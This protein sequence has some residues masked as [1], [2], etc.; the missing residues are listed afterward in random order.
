MSRI[1]EGPN[2]EVA[3]AAAGINIAY[4]DASTH[5]DTCADAITSPADPAQM[6][7]SEIDSPEA[8]IPYPDPVA[9]ANKRA[10][11]SHALKKVD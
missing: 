5:V 2:C 10:G 11:R 4:N 3:S 9:A 8:R 7:G 6:K 1:P